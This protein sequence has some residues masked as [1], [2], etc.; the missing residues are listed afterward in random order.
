MQ[1]PSKVFSKLYFDMTGILRTNPQSALDGI[2]KTLQNQRSK[3]KVNEENNNNNNNK[4][5]QTNTKH[6]HFLLRLFYW[7]S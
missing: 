2:Q 3:R 5:T 7:M 4:K 1:S 6:S